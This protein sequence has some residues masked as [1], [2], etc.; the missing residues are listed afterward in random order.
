[1]TKTEFALESFKNIQ[2]LIKFIDQKAGAILVLAGLLFSAFIELSKELAFTS[3]QD[4]T[5]CGVLAAITGFATV[6][7]LTYMV[8]VSI[9]KI[10]RPR[11]AN[12]YTNGEL[13]LFYFEHI[14]GL[15]KDE[16][17]VSYEILDET[18]MIKYLVEQQFEISKILK[19][20]TDALSSVFTYLFIAIVALGIFAILANQL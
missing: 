10:L 13:S 17:L 9:D 7:C 12:H 3:F 1:M 6:I 20:K 14:A 4:A 15:N 8:Y 16:L 11:L 5:I 2:D 19:K 18:K